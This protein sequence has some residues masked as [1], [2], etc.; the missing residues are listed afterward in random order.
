[1]AVIELKAGAR[2]DMLTQSELD[3]SL[4]KHGGLSARYQ[5]RK[6]L[7]YPRQLATPAGSA[8]ALRSEASGGPKLGYVWAFR[9]LVVTGLTSGTTPDVVNL[10]R[11]D[12]QDVVW[13][14]TGNAFFFKFGMNEVTLEGGDWWRL[15]SVGTFAATGVI[16]LTGELVEVP[17]ALAGAL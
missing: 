2:L 13:Q 3:E 17:A 1:M 4:Q 12:Q 11:G 5:G 9:R 10:F 7:R 6:W 15:A 8:L 16:S 14:F